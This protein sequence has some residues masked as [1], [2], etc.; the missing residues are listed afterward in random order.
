MHFP[1]QY[2]TSVHESAFRKCEDEKPLLKKWEGE[3]QTKGVGGNASSFG[4][5]CSREYDGIEEENDDVITQHSVLLAKWG[6]FETQRDAAVNNGDPPPP[7]PTNQFKNNKEIKSCPRA[8]T[9]KQLKKARRLC[10][11]NFSM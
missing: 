8:V 5:P 11:P 10:E 1:A 7:F 3:G 4:L 9:A 2:D 6:A